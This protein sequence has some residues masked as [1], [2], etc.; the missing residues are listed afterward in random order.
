MI[1]LNNVCKYYPLRRGK[2]LV[3]DDISFVLRKG[4]RLGIMGYNGSG[5]STLV[6]V[7]G[8]AEYP[9]SGTIERRMR[10]SWPLAFQGGFSGRMSGLDNLR[11]ICRVYDVP[12]EE[13]L[14]KVVDF[15]GLGLYLREPMA[16]YSSGMRAKM[17]FAISMAVDF[18]CYLIDEVTA[19]GDIRFKN[20][21]KEILLQRR[22]EKSIIMVSHVP[23]VILE[24]CNR[25]SVLYHGKLALFDD[26]GAA[27]AFYTD[28]LKNPK[29]IDRF[30]ET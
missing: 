11:F 2:R 10:L 6:R 27:N 20:R 22:N 15:T 17:A 19:V 8:G 13:V 1:I 23:A 12:Y 24:Y 4:E 14:P 5:K 9:S 29:D 26:Y 28:M 3:L 18:D 30:E 16:R 7:I 21:C 25:F